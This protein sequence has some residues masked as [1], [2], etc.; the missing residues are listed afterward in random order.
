MRLPDSDGYTLIYD[1]LEEPPNIL[2]PIICIIIAIFGFY[3]VGSS[4]SKKNWSTKD[5]LGVTDGTKKAI[6]GLVLLVGGLGMAYHFLNPSEYSKLKKMTKQEN[7]LIVSGK[8]TNLE[9]DYHSKHGHIEFQINGQRF[10]FYDGGNSYGC[11]YNDLADENIQ[12][13]TFLEIHYLK[14]DGQNVAVRIRTK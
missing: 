2:G 9:R 7:L 5:I 3:L 4:F 14:K 12:D 8:V 1:F 6:I 13:S 10:R 11:G